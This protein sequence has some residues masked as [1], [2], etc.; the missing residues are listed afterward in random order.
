M[1]S[2]IDSMDRAYD[3]EDS[4]KHLGLA[5]SRYWRRHAALDSGSVS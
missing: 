3:I 4:R 2:V 5:A 1:V